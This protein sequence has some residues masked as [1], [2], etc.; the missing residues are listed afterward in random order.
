MKKD[1]EFGGFIYKVSRDGKIFG[2]NDVELKQRLDSDGYPVVTLGNKKIRRTVQRVHQIVARAFV[3]NTHSK[4]EVNHIDGVKTN[5][6]Y[7]NLEWST[8]QEQMIHAF[9]LGLKVGSKGAKNGRARL[10]E[11]DVLE[12]RKLYSQGWKISQLR[13]KFVVGWTTIQ[14][15]VSGDTWK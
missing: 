4:P 13:D 5:N 9:K 15:I 10:S 12:I 6:H 1:F 7:K 11:T 8:R 3:Y 2:K 14:H